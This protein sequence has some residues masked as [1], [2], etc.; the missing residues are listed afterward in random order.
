[1]LHGPGDTIR[2]L[3]DRIETRHT[4]GTGCTLSSAIAT[5]L[6]AGLSLEQ[7]VERGIRFVEA[8]LKAAPGYGAGHGPLGH[9]AVGRT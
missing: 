5:G 4:H 2:F 1:M 6:G 3:T 9:Q 7:A 8:A